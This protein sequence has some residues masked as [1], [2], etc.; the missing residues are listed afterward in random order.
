MFILEICFYVQSLRIKFAK[1]AT[2]EIHI[3]VL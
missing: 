2:T 3:H 1:H